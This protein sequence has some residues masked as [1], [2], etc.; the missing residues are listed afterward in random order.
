[1]FKDPADERQRVWNY[2]FTLTDS[3]VHEERLNV[4]ARISQTSREMLY[5]NGQVVELPGIPRQHHAVLRAASGAQQ[6][7]VSLGAVLKIPVL[8]D[9]CTWFSTC[10]SITDF[11]VP[12]MNRFPIRMLPAG[13]AD[14]MD[15]QQDVVHFL[16]AFGSTIT[17]FDVVGRLLRRPGM[18]SLPCTPSTGQR[19][20]A[21]SGCRLGG[22]T[23]KTLALYPHLQHVLNAGG[24]LLIDGLN[25]SLHPLLVHGVIQIFLDPARN[26]L[27]AQ[28]LFTS[29]DSWIL[30]A[31]ILRR[32]EIWTAEKHDGASSLYSLAEFKLENKENVRKDAGYMK[33]YLLGRYGGIPDMR[34][35]R[36]RE[37]G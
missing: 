24:L 22:G 27:H 28:L 7:L 33:N 5:R 3:N 21:S 30:N 19:R 13:F 2:G 32:N 35:L 6:L 31:E 15:V 1:M 11:E 10:T 37:D 12:H 9:V 8:K 26:S 4:R 29:H 20:A 34:P 23:L 18:V 25:A 14:N 16:S 17:G 36:I